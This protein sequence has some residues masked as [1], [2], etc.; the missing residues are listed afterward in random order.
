MAKATQEFGEW[1]LKRLMTEIVGSG[2]KSAD[3]MTREQAREAFQRI[4]ADE[5]DET[6]LGAFWLAN[7][8]KRNN[9]EELAGYTD[10]MLEESV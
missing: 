7:R 9:P 8:W 5:P 2:P 6:T 3:D 1:P 4:L 10:V